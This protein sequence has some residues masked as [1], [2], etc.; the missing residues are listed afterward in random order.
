MNK[1][2]GIFLVAICQIVWAEQCVPYARSRSGIQISGDAYTWWGKAKSKGSKPYVGA[3]MSMPKQGG[4]PL[5]QS[6]HVAFVARVIS[7]TEIIIDHAN[8][9]GQET[10]HL[11]V[12]V[13]DVSG[14]WTSVN[15]EN[16]PGSGYG[17]SAYTIDGFI[18]PLGMTASNPNC[19]ISS[20]KCSVRSP[21]SS[22][23]GWFPP[24][25]DCQQASQ[26]YNMATVTVNG[27]K[28]AVGST[29]KSACPQA[30]FAN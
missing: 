8:W 9:D 25:D 19:N 3:V 15:I 2:I 23:I 20:W 16:T 4:G 13:R 5:G 14:N 27:E 1:L 11:G 21:K 10:R 30:C 24:V 28:I 26:W 7:S 6:G 22:N 12:K 18:Y 17:P 29:T